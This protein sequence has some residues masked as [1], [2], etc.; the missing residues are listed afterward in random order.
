MVPKIRFK[1]I[2]PFFGPFFGDGDNNGGRQFFGDQFSYFIR[3]SHL[4]TR[5][6]VSY[7]VLGNFFSTN[8]P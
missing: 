2:W 5:L 1:K 3:I 6:Q 7:G 8:W 4:L